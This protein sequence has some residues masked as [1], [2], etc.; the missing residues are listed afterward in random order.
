ME[1]FAKGSA[2]RRAMPRGYLKEVNI[3][4][5]AIEFTQASEVGDAVITAWLAE[6]I[7]WVLH[8]ASVK[9]TLGQVRF[10]AAWVG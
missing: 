10:L 5:E 1:R 2:W 7:G 6:N 3:G 9:L 4:I 8:P